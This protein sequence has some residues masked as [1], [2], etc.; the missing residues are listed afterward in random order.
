VNGLQQSIKFRGDELL[1]GRNRLE[2][3]ERAGIKLN[4]LGGHAIERLPAVDA[5]GYIISLN[6]HR[7]HLTKQQ[8]ADLI[9]AALLAGKA[10]KQKAADK[11][12]ADKYIA[13]D[14]GAPAEVSRQ[15]GEKVRDGR[16][17]DLVK[18]EAVAIAKKEG[19]GKRTVERAFA[20]ADGKKPKTLKPNAV[21]KVGSSHR[22]KWAQEPTPEEVL[23]EKR[24][25]YLRECEKQRVDLDAEQAIIITAFR[26]LAGKKAMA[27]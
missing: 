24:S 3:I 26:E 10:A 21:N 23:D 22:P 27:A 4:S 8:Q 5:V 25:S 6:I 2:A 16:P 20:K 15:L 1:D 17:R 19:I 12:K 13:A 14:G 7:R 11:A 9:V 18:A